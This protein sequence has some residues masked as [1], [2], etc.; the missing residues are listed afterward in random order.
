MHG[1][2]DS[3]VER[4]FHAGL[5]VV[6]RLRNLHVDGNALGMSLDV[7][8][9]GDA[10]GTPQEAGSS[11]ARPGSLSA[12]ASLSLSVTCPKGTSPDIQSP[13]AWIG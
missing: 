2:P 8:D 5:L 7:A 3:E 10:V 1:L 4:D 11:S 12:R 9:V 6:V 13:I